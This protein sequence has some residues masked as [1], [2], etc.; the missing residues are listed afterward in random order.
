MKTKTH[1]K[2]YVPADIFQE[3]IRGMQLCA[4][5]QEVTTENFEEMTDI[6][7]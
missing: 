2:P 1:K 6:T 3:D 5:S 4:T 7:W